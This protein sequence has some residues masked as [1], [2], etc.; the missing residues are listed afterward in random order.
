[1]LAPLLLL[2]VVRWG[3]SA[4]EFSHGFSSIPT[5]LSGHHKFMGAA[6]IGTKVFLAP[7]Y[8]DGAAIIDT[9]TSELSMVPTGLSG[10]DKFWGA[11]A[12]GTKAVFAPYGAAV[13]GIADAVTGLFTGL[14]HGL[15]GS[16]HLGGRK[17]GGG[18]TSR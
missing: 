18:E 6:G 15:S 5:G 16:G 2:L 3:G 4:S 7:H 10:N 17:D 14:A 9:A 12:V 1:M 8:Q 11:A 13:V